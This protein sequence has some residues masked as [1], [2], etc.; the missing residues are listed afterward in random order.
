MFLFFKA[1]PPNKSTLLR[2]ETG[3]PSIQKRFNPF[4]KD[5]DQQFH[6]PLDAPLDSQDAI[7]ASVDTT[8]FGKTNSNEANQNITPDTNQIQSS[9]GS[10][11]SL[12]E[13]V[14]NMSI[15]NEDNQNALH[16]LHQ[17]SLSPSQTVQETSNLER[18][19]TIDASLDAIS[20][21]VVSSIGER[22]DQTQPDEHLADWI[23]VGESVLI[24]PYNTSG[25]I[26]FV[27]KTHFQVI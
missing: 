23:V 26:A 2:Q 19:Q 7:G 22:I 14:S 3:L 13:A 6:E 27:G 15:N 1:S 20:K 11:D 10:T 21:S 9:F 16:E 17:K 12:K 8:E 18:K 4:L 25:V 24:R 5:A